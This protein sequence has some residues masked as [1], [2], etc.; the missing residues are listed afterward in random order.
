MRNWNAPS[1][2]NTLLP[3]TQCMSFPVTI[4][5]TPTAACRGCDNTIRARCVDT[6]CHRMTHGGRN[7]NANKRH[8]RIERTIYRSSI[9]PCLDD[10]RVS[11]VQS[12]QRTI[13]A[14]ISTTV[15]LLKQ[16]YSIAWS[17]GRALA[18]HCL[19]SSRW[20]ISR[21]HRR[22]AL[23]ICDGVEGVKAIEHQ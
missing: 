11:A 1:A 18:D 20:C 13:M 4:H 22:D 14:L 5:F 15:L 23:V 3:K 12:V 17:L 6:S 9:T 7:K 21:M 10:D 2:F 16:K 8:R 19:V